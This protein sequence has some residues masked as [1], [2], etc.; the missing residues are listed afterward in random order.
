MLGRKLEKLA[1][2]F[3]LE[4]PTEMRQ[5]FAAALFCHMRAI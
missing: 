1:G 2:L 4:R 3:R 5:R